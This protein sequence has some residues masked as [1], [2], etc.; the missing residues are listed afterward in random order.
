M[1]DMAVP[2][3]DAR[4]PGGAYRSD[5]HVFAI[6]RISTTERLRLITGLEV[7][8]PLARSS[9]ASPH[10]PTYLLDIIRAAQA[11]RERSQPPR[12]PACT[13]QEWHRI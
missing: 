4:S 12:R 13:W 1:S 3:P 7:A 2:G 9:T 11:P 10:E 5:G 8:R 6:S